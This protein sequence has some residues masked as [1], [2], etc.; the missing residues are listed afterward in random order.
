MK[1]GMLPVRD[2]LRLGWNII[3]WFF[4]PRGDPAWMN[5]TMLLS[6]AA[7]AIGLSYGTVWPLCGTIAIAVACNVY[8]HRSRTKA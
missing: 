4:W 7:G 5:I 6:V 8:G 2:Q 3:R 1:T